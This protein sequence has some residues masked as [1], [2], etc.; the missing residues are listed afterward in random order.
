MIVKSGKKYQL[1]IP[2]KNEIIAKDYEMIQ[3]DILHGENYYGKW[4]ELNSN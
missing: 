1:N 4:L 2:S 3:Y